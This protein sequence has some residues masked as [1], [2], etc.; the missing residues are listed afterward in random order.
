MIDVSGGFDR[1]ERLQVI[2]D[3]DALAELFQAPINGLYGIINADGYIG[4]WETG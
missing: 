4:P 1:I 3:R 2:T